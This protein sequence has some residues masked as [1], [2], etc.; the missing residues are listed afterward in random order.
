[1]NIR[2][3]ASIALALVGLS[4]IGVS[5]NA[6]AC[7]LSLIKTANGKWS[8]APPAKM[9]ASAAKLMFLAATPG[10]RTRAIPNPLQYLEPIAGLWDVTLTAERNPPGTVFSNGDVADHGYSVWHADGSEIMNSGRPAGDSNFCLGTWAQTGPRT[11]TL[12]H[13]TLSWFQMVGPTPDPH[14]PPLPGLYYVNNIF[15][16]PGNIS[17]TVTLAKDGKSYS[18]QFT[19]TQYDTGGNVAPGFPI[20]GDVAATRLTINSPPFSF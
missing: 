3:S 8:I 16:G 14:T 2:L 11:Y 6:D 12:N 4:T 7:G 19:I 10:S 9:S 1:M 20:T 18:G 17:E 5:Q 15:A 13:Y